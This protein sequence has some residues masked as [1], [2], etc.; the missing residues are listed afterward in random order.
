MRYL[1]FFFFL[2]VFTFASEIENKELN[3]DAKKINLETI[4]INKLS[5]KEKS[6]Q[7]YKLKLEE[8][9]RQLEED[10]FCSCNNN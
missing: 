7:E 10:G 2:S 8:E 5:E 3:K 9:N 6:Y 1:F 4:V